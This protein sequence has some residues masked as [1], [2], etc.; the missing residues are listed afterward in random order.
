MIERVYRH[1][2]SSDEERAR[3]ISQK[4]PGNWTIPGGSYIYNLSS[5]LNSYGVKAYKAQ[6]VQYANVYA[7]L[8]Y[9]ATFSTPAIAQ[10]VWYKGGAHFVMCAFRDWD[11][12]FVFYDP[13]Y[14]IVEISGKDFPY[15]YAYGGKMTPQ[16]TGEGY[17]N[18][19]ICLTYR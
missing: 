13:F 19:W 14:G 4:Y 5:I 11:D 18:G 17:F 10:V 15:Y 16:T 12:T 2:G 6:Y 9:Y 1:L 8:K 7:Y 3:K